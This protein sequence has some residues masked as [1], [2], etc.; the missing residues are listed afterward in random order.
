MVK[1]K[2]KVKTRIVYREAKPSFDKEKSRR[3]LQELE[4]KRKQ[5]HEEV[6]K[7]KEGKKGFSK[8]AASLGGLT[9]KAS[10]NK[11]ISQKRKVLGS[12]EKAQQIQ[13]QIQFVKQKTEL[14]KAQ[15]ELQQV[16][17]K[18]SVDFGNIFGEKRQVGAIKESDIFR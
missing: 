16:R 12:Q 6:E 3:E 5:I 9:R 17:E 1:K 4:Q 11:A 7:Q 10:I 8:F 14:A 2:Q 15:Q 18:G 13:G